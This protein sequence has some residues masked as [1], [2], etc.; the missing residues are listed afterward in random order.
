M[1]IKPRWWCSLHTEAL[2]NLTDEPQSLRAITGAAEVMRDLVH[3][4]IVKV[5]YIQKGLYIVARYQKR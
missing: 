2:N 4:N 1:N 5:T 3:M